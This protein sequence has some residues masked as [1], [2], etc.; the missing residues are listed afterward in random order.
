MPRLFGNSQ[1]YIGVD[2]GQS[3]GLVIIRHD[4]RVSSCQ[5]P[6]TE[7]DVWNWCYNL[8]DTD[9]IAVIEHVHSMPGQ[10]VA[11]SFK[12]GR[13]YGGLRMALIAANIPFEE[14][15]PQRWQKG[16][17]IPARKKTESKTQ[18]KNRLKAKAQQL[19]PKVP[20]TLATAD[21]LLIAEYCRRKHEGMLG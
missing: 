11:S 15:T 12:F 17:A 1:A 13:G 6:K 14:V 9:A 18:F 7:R 21:A 10:G 20:V 3:G 2:P 8:N 16:L 4:G 5:M 19:F